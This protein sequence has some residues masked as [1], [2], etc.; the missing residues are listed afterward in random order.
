MSGSPSAKVREGSDALPQS[1]PPRVRRMRTVSDRAAEHIRYYRTHSDKVK[2]TTAK[3]AARLTARIAE[4]KA[5]PCL[6]CGGTFPP[7][8]MDFDHR[9]GEVKLFGVSHGKAYAWERVE[10]EIAKCDLVC[11]NCHRIRTR[12][13]R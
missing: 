1:A 2:A 7:E 4:L 8:C 11:A 3:R 13:R 6:D 9:P 12:A 10:A 5:N